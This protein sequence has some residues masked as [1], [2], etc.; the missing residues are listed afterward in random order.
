MSAFAND[1]VVAIGELEDEIVGFGG[2]GGGFDFLLSGGGFAVGDVL[3]DGA[4]EQE[5]ILADESHCAAQA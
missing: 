4:V 2:F 5:D 3:A 1:G